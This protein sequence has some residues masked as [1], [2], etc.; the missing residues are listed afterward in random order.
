MGGETEK[1]KVGEREREGR[2][3]EGDRERRDT[4]SYTQRKCLTYT[5]YNLRIKMYGKGL[6]CWVDIF[7]LLDL[8]DGIFYYVKVF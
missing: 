1:E 3:R 2:E 7:P 6:C 8:K 4:Y 5:K